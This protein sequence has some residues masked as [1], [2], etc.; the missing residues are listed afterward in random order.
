MVSR[1]K[2]VY[3]PYEWLNILRTKSKY[4]FNFLIFWIS[5]ALTYQRTRK[6]YKSHKNRKIPHA[7]ELNPKALIALRNP[8]SQDFAP[9]L[10]FNWLGAYCNTSLQNLYFS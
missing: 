5:S 3:F 2:V 9:I 8:N 4:P 1:R 7:R 6:S 10:L